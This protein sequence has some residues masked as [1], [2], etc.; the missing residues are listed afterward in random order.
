MSAHRG[1]APSAGSEVQLISADVMIRGNTGLDTHQCAA[2][3]VPQLDGPAAFVEPTIPPHCISAT[4]TGSTPLPGEVGELEPRAGTKGPRRPLLR[5]P[6]A[7]PA[8]IRRGERSGGGHRDLC[9]AQ[10]VAGSLL[11]G[12]TFW[13]SRWAAGILWLL[14]GGSPAASGMSAPLLRERWDWL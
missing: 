2:V 1:C 9:A 3:P 12:V 5:T 8:L 4:R 13:L 11:V 7:A 14:Q 6:V 10:R